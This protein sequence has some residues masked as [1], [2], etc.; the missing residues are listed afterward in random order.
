[1]GP[2]QVARGYIPSLDGMRAA[3][4]LIVF[5]SHAKLSPLIP[6]GFGVTVFFFLSGYLITALLVR[7]QEKH[8]RIA[9]HAFY[10]RR[11]VRLAPPLLTT[12]A[13]CTLAVLLGLAAGDLSLDVFLSQVFFFSNYYGPSGARTSVEGLEILWSLAVEEHFYLFYPVL[14]I[15]LARGWIRLRMLL[16]LIGLT[17]LWRCTRFYLLGDGEWEIY[18]STDTR[19]DSMLFGCLLALIAARGWAGRLLPRRRMYPV[20]GGAIGLLLLSFAFQDAAFRSTLRYTVQGIALMPIFH[21]AVH[22]PNELIFKPLNWEW[23]RRIGQCSYTFYL[24]H[25]VVI[26]ALQFN[27]MDAGNQLL[28]IPVAAALSLGFAVL[29]LEFVE[30]PLKPLRARLTGYHGSV[31]APTIQRL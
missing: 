2:D 13:V 29:V 17:L 30:K 25:F 1:M 27:G 11:L 28:F 26:A 12:L 21:Y 6:G 19:I 22:H 18:V 23:V 20:L 9:L 7:E 24:I 5:L 31:S 16:H 4:I 3:S 10:L 15:A 14:F 8:G